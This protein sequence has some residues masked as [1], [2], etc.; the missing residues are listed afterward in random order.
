MLGMLVCKLGMLTCKYPQELGQH[1]WVLCRKAQPPSLHITE[2]QVGTTLGKR[3][4][5]DNQMYLYKSQPESSGL[6]KQ[7]GKQE[8]ENVAG[9][10]RMRDHRTETFKWSEEPCPPGC[11]TASG[12]SVSSGVSGAGRRGEVCP[13]HLERGNHSVLA[14][15]ESLSPQGFISWEGQW[16]SWVYCTENESSSLKHEVKHLA[17]QLSD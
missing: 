16:C 15:K 1:S 17:P 11:S 14:P 10:E 12:L 6:K 2:L 13:S 8:R 5:K 7:R 9:E 3:A 4:G